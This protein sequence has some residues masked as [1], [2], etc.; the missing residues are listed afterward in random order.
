MGT[1]SRPIA[2]AICGALAVVMVVMVV[3]DQDTSIKEAALDGLFKGA[4]SQGLKES[5]W[6]EAREEL[7]QV[8][9]PSDNADECVVERHDG[10]SVTG[11]G[12]AC[13]AKRFTETA[14]ECH[15]A[16]KGCVQD[17]A[18]KH[19]K[20][21]FE[22]C[23]EAAKYGAK[24]GEHQSA[25]TA[26]RKASTKVG[27]SAEEHKA[28]KARVKSI[29]AAA[30][31]S[32]SGESE[33]MFAAFEGMSSDQVEKEMESEEEELDPPSSDDD[34]SDKPS[35]DNQFGVYH[36]CMASKV[37]MCHDAMGRAKVRTS[38]FCA[39]K[40]G[41]KVTECKRSAKKVRDNCLKQHD[42]LY[43]N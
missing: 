1:M 14:T 34:E 29:A 9:K 16:L 30:S 12:K 10:Y 6:D 5:Q 17:R 19:L 15:S 22:T 2:A 25:S 4:H 36:K 32:P 28:I 31:G 13:C 33:L 3:Q 23:E 8:F 35:L 37:Q 7:D 39:A 38:A 11:H 41:H 26:N 27:M 43:Q 18:A 42:S 24:K 40:H 21:L 20:P